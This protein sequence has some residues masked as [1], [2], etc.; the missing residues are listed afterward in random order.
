MS[1]RKPNAAINVSETQLPW[2]GSLSLTP[3][4]GADADQKTDPKPPPV[5]WVLRPNDGIPRG[6]EESDS[7]RAFSI[8][9]DTR[10]VS[11]VVSPKMRTLVRTKFSNIRE[12][13]L[14]FTAIIGQLP[15]YDDRMA[16]SSYIRK[17]VEERWKQNVVDDIKEQLDAAVAARPRDLHEESDFE[18]MWKQIGFTEIDFEHNCSPDRSTYTL[19]WAFDGTAR[20]T[21]YFT[22]QLTKETLAREGVFVPPVAKV[23]FSTSSGG[24]VQRRYELTTA[25]TDYVLYRKPPYNRRWRTITILTAT[26]DSINPFD[27]KEVEEAYTVDARIKSGDNYILRE[28]VEEPKDLSAANEE[29]NLQE[30]RF[31]YLKNPMLY[32]RAAYKT[33][34]AA[35]GYIAE[36]YGFENMVEDANNPGVVYPEHM[37]DNLRKVFD[38]P[39]PGGGELKVDRLVGTLREYY[40]V[41]MDAAAADDLFGSDDE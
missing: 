25:N 34:D 16:I 41:K 33:Y 40:A 10:S 4:I 5:S 26:G 8:A 9:Y 37:M 11:E 18:S 2:L 23:T 31:P 27:E 38:Y 29:W 35:T 39:P 6:Y 3:S 7:A 32:R 36:S 28:R 12:E 30:K 14:V 1:T 21:K 17:R 20:R 22:T 15:K 24:R 19:V 13:D